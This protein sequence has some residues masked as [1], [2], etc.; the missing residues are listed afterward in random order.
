MFEFSRKLNLIGSITSPG[1]ISTDAHIATLL[2]SNC[3]HQLLSF[4][5]NKRFL[6]QN[7]ASCRDSILCWFVSAKQQSWTNI[8]VIIKTSQF[9]KSDSLYIHVSVCLWKTLKGAHLT[10]YTSPYTHFIGT[11]DHNEHHLSIFWTYRDGKTAAPK[12]HTRLLKCQLCLMHLITPTLTWRDEKYKSYGRKI[13][14]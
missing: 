1:L 4:K 11:G 5:M 6:K 12:V 8:L 9:F 10:N 14:P 3:N 7:Q 13:L 2:K